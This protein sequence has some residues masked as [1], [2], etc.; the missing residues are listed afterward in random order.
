MRHYEELP[1][2]PDG[3]AV[4]GDAV[5]GFNPIY[6]QG[7]TNA[8]I[9]ATILAGVLRRSDSHYAARFQ[10]MLARHNATPWLLATNEDFRFPA[11]EGDRPGRGTWLVQRYLDRVIIASLTRRD[12]L[13]AFFAVAHMV[14]GPASLFRPRDS[15]GLARLTTAARNLSPS[16]QHHGGH[17]PPS[18][19]DFP[20]ARHTPGTPTPVRRRTGRGAQRAS[21]TAGSGGDGS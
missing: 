6:G 18:G 7:M 9:G 17:P 1:E 10:K 20:I 12:V 19:H 3:F 21:H 2:W 14:A 16:A 11:T 4:T 15:P 8:A 13:L 5:C